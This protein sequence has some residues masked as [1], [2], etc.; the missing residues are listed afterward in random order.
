[1]TAFTVAMTA[2]GIAAIVLA[3]LNIET[4]QTLM[5]LFVFGFIATPWVA[6]YLASVTPTR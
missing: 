3:A 6:N 4:A 5:V 1:M 2:V